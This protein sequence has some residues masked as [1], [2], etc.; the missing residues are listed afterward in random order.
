LRPARE[1][2]CAVV[3]TYHPDAGIRMRIRTLAS[4]VRRIVIVDNGSKQASLDIL[5]GIVEET[6]AQL[7]SN[8]ENLGI[9]TALNQGAEW[10][11]DQGYAWLLTLD[12]DS[13]VDHDLVMGLLDVHEQLDDHSGVGM[14]APN[15]RS[16]Y[17]ERWKELASRPH[18]WIPRHTVITSGSL[19]SLY[20]FSVAGRFRDDFFID[21]VDTEYCLRLRERGYK[22]YMTT[23]PLMTHAIG[24]QTLHKLL[25][26]NVIATNHSALRRYYIAR[27]RLVL[28]SNYKMREPRAVWREFKNMILDSVT[29]ALFEKGKKAKLCAIFTGLRDGIIGRMGKKADLSESRN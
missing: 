21:M 2:I 20:A 28:A 27:N 9:A 25:W 10:A 4:Q 19:L 8:Q 6:N 18:A 22:I 24:N 23:R 5:R 7:I 13:V 29:I 14:I 16:D 12:Q 3:V 15:F 1:N 17:G 11:L 26:A